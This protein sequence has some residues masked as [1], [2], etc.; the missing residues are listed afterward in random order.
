[1]FDLG[2]KSETS[3][4]NDCP[5]AVFV[6]CNKNGTFCNNFVLIHKRSK[7]VYL[8]KDRTTAP[9]QTSYFIIQL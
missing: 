1:M 9:T 7:C 3:V 4:L 6:L 5:A 8:K 2:D